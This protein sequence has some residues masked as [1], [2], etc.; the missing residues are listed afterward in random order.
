MNKKIALVLSLLCL[1]SCGTSASNESSPSSAQS[2]ESSFT[3]TPT[4]SSQSESK[5]EPPADK[6]A[7]F[8]AF[9]AGFDDFYDYDD[10][11]A[12]T[13]SMAASEAEGEEEASMRMEGKGTLDRKNGLYYLGSKTYAND[14]TTETEVEVDADSKYIGVSDGDYSYYHFSSGD[15]T[16]YAADKTSAAYLFEYDFIDDIGI[17]YIGSVVSSAESYAV[18]SSAIRYLLI[19]YPSFTCDIGK[20]DDGGITL[21]INMESYS[22]YNTFERITTEC[23]MTVKDGYLSDFALVASSERT[24]P[25]KSLVKEKTE[26]NVGFKKGFDSALYSTFTDQSSYTDSG[27]GMEVKVR[28]YYD[29]YYYDSF[30]SE[31]GGGLDFSYSWN[32]LFEGVYYDK[33][34]TI[35]ASSKKF[36]SDARKVYIKLKTT[37]DS[38]NAIIYVLTDKTSY[39]PDDI[40]P[41]KTE[42]TIDAYIKTS[43]A[44][45]S[46][47]WKNSDTDERKK[48]SETY[49]VNG[50]A[51]SDNSVSISLGSVYFIEHAYSCFSA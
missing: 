31:I 46:L 24:Y 10:D 30:Y 43:A 3:P 33:D 14:P 50:I 51:T 29:G 18:F 4:S 45:Y 28:A 20:A 37:A 15:K 38:S 27:K 34:F 6:E 7:L 9:K 32:D 44:T 47:S 17:D 39:Y 26:M 13:F 1:A 40:I 41:K 36:S 2:Q 11:L 21:D 5:D 23:I 48:C 25:D 19:D 8:A 16:R 12:F 42:K 49:K 22:L 35:P